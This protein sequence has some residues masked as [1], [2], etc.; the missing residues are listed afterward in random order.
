MAACQRPKLASHRLQQ[1]LLRSLSSGLSSGLSFPRSI[2][3]GTGGCATQGT[4]A[5]LIG[6][7]RA[8]REG[9]SGRGFAELAGQ[10]DLETTPFHAQFR[11][12][13]RLLFATRFG[14]LLEGVILSAAH[15]AVAVVILRLDSPRANQTQQNQ[16][17][18]MQFQ[19]QFQPQFQHHQTHSARA[20]PCRPPK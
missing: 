3:E 13:A 14:L 17:S 2:G 15:G 19:P 7:K 20:R 5:E 4:S 16:A 8:F 11:D 6:D 1:K 12:A 18:E 10:T 9:I